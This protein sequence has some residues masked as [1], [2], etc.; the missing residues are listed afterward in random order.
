MVFFK[1]AIV[2]VLD[3]VGI[4]ELPD[5]H[6]YGDEG[7]NTVGNIA[8][9]VALNVPT[10]HS[11]GLSR[12]VRL[13]HVPAPATPQGAYGRMAERSAG[14]DSVTGHWELMGVIIDRAF[15]TFPQGFPQPMIE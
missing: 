8:N 9:Q 15:P 1:R 3:S 11:L 13:S 4:G 2:I 6:L 10:L 14:K 12:L 5:A 7:S